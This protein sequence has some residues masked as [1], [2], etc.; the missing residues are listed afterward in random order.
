MIVKAPWCWERS[1]GEHQLLSCIEFVLQHSSKIFPIAVV[2]G[3]GAAA[4]IWGSSTLCKSSFLSTFVT[5]RQ[6]KVEIIAHR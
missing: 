3:A 4:E 1:S 2:Q 6:P 5:T